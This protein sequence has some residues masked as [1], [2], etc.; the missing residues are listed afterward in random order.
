MRNAIA[1]GETAFKTSLESVGQI[2]KR[3][4]ARMMA[5]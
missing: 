4:A 1:S 2:P 5:R 3:T